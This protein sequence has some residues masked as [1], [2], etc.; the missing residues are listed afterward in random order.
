MVDAIAFEEHVLGTAEADAFGTE[1]DGVG[2]LVGLVGVGADAQGAVL[3]GQ[4]HDEVVVLEQFESLAGFMV[5]SIRTWISSDGAVSILPA[6]ISPVEPLMEMKSPSLTVLPV[7]GHGALGVV[8]VEFAGTGDADLTHLTGNHGGVRAHTTLGGEDTGSGDHAAQVFRAGFDTSQN[9]GTMLGPGLQPFRRRSRAHRWRHQD[10]RA[11][12]WSA[13][14][15]PS[16][17]VG[18]GF[19]VED[20]GHQLFDG[21]GVGRA[22]G[23]LGGHQLLLHHVVG[24]LDVGLGGALAVTGL[25][26]V[27]TLVLDGEFEV[28]N[29]AEFFFEL[30]A[31]GFEFLVGL[32]PAWDP[33]PCPG[34]SAGCGYRPPR[35][36][37]GR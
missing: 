8:D 17:G 19:L 28:L 29:V 21:F 27:Q 3:V 23:V 11:D 16:D 33:W 31:D 12:R 26:Q 32:L 1:G 15:R 4:L 13:R 9:H 5:L 24:D 14:R 2:G 18:V 37:P 36:R 6:R 35:L 7:A 34:S 22:D 30:L 10:Q 20:R 25:Q